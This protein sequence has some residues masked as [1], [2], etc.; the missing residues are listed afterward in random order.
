MFDT[1][2]A[3]RTIGDD[4]TI[5]PLDEVASIPCNFDNQ[6]QKERHLVSFTGQTVGDSV[7]QATT[8]D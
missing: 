6:I 8:S 1:H 5:A 3:P 2:S 7:D 4:D